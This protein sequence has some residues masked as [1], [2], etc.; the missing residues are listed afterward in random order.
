ME[1]FIPSV[2]VLLLA[3]AMVFFILPRFGAPVLALISVGLLA[4]G[5]YQHMNAFKDEYRFSTWQQSLVNYA[6]YVMIGGLLVV[7]AFYLLTISPL[8]KPTAPN[9]NM[10]EMP[11]VNKMPSANTATNAITAGV[12]NALKGLTNAAGTAAAAAGIGNA[13]K[14]GNAN[15][16]AAGIAAPAV[17]AVNNAAK[18]AAEGVQGA[19][20]GLTSAANQ[21]KNAVTG[22]ASKGNGKGPNLGQGLGQALGLGT[23]EPTAPKAN[24]R[25]PNNKGLGVP[26]LKFPLS[27]I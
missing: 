6:P 4:F 7:V 8:G 12:N 9:V 20:S 17:A 3:A 13:A 23:G 15:K 26:G 27:Q 1:L 14:Q 22:N 16:G 2:L 11:S 21:L 10:P 19:L 5:I 25:P 24:N 18:K